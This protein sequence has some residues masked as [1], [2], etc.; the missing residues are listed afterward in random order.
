MVIEEEIMKKKKKKLVSIYYQPKKYK[1]SQIKRTQTQN[2]KPK[3]NQIMMRYG[4]D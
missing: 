3:T 2:S 1:P 4:F